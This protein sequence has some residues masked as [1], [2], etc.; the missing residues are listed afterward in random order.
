MDSSASGRRWLNRFKYHYN[1]S[2]LI[3]L[4]MDKHLPRRY[5]TRQCRPDRKIKTVSKE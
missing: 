4:S 1:R 3:K 5:L 2:D